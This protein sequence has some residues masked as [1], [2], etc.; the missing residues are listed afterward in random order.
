MCED[1][2]AV[3]EIHT[4]EGYGLDIFPR[5][6]CFL[7]LPLTLATPGAP[8]GEQPYTPDQERSG[9]AMEG[10]AATKL[11]QGPPSRR[12]MDGASVPKLPQGV[13]PPPDTVLV[14]VAGTK[15]SVGKDSC[16]A[17][18]RSS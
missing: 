10:A 6:E 16:A 17:H 8:S 14:N 1:P 4:C 5:Y 13:A 11:Q 9:G 12:V 18:Q 3:K 7:S 2:A 15:Y